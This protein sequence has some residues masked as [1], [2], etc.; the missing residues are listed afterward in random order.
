MTQ[1]EATHSMAL[2]KVK[3]KILV[4]LYNSEFLCKTLKKM[5]I[6]AEKQVMLIFFIKT[7][8]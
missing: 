2:Q 3:Y 6:A 1:R 7:K 8:I 4:K 5:F